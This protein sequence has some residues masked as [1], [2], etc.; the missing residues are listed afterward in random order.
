MAGPFFGLKIEWISISKSRFFTSRSKETLKTGA[1]LVARR[2]KY[3]LLL[4]FGDRRVI[5]NFAHSINQLHR[6]IKIGSSG[7][8]RCRNL[9]SALL[10][11]SGKRGSQMNQEIQDNQYAPTPGETDGSELKDTADWIVNVLLRI[12]AGSLARVIIDALGF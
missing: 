12:G 1:N 3:L 4:S 5:R 2:T 11:P 6:S 8:R 10:P 7:S 9:A